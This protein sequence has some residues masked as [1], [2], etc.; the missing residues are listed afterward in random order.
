MP[1][2]LQGKRAQRSLQGL[3]TA[4]KGGVSQP[5]ISGE[6]DMASP[7]F[8]APL[9]PVTIPEPGTG[10]AWVL[11]RGPQHGKYPEGPIQDHPG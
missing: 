5:P 7:F 11:D 1:K 2:D 3:G 9:M 6:R 8:G 4:S 10:V